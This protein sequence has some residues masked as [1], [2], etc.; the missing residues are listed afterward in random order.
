MMDRP[1]LFS[2][3]MVR[4]ILEG[5]K[6]QT[7]RVIKPQPNCIH[8]NKQMIWQS[9]E[10]KACPYGQRRGILIFKTT[11]AVAKDYDHLK[12]SQ[13]PKFLNFWSLFDGTPRPDWCGKSRPGRFLPKFLYYLMPRGEIVNVRV[14]RV[15][16]ISEND[17]I[18]EGVN[19][20]LDPFGDV[21]ITAKE[22][23]KELWDSIN[24]KKYPWSSNP[25]V[26]VI[27][28][29]RITCAP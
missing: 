20:F 18:T 12:P 22:E 24:G 15:Q 23:Y 1:I 28:F 6:T 21:L 9:D 11:W 3:E 14:E 7:R 10:W 19:L 16:D 17:A 5:R 4:A 26:W 25:V 27:E 8:D 2:G 13:L 29:K